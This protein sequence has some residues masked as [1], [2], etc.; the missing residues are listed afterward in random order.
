[1]STESREPILHD[2]RIH[3][4]NIDLCS[5]TFELPSFNDGVMIDLSRLLSL[6]PV[7]PSHN[8]TGQWESW[9][10]CSHCCKRA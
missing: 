4:I 8:L 1:M 5:D 3:T 9:N 10:L 7:G 6:I 2:F